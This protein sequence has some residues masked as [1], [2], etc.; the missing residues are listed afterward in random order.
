MGSRS[1]KEDFQIAILRADRV[2]A[3]SG[4]VRWHPAFG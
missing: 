3:M 4:D 1:T 2:A